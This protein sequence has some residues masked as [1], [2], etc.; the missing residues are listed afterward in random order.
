MNEGSI[1]RRYAKALLELAREESAVDRIGEDLARVQ[2]ACDVNNA[3]LGLVM[4]NPVF[5][6]SERRAV[7]DAV[8][9]T[10]ALHA[11]AVNFMKLLLDKDRFSAL[12]DIVRE[13]GVLADLEANRVRA[14]VTTSGALS[15]GM[16]DA[17][18][19]SLAATTG[20]KVVLETKVD[21][22][23]IGGMVARVGG[24]VYDASLRTRLEEL[25]LSLA[26]PAQS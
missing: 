10:L 7:L 22:A 11:H 6:Q 18:S 14:T 4:S 13:Y 23:L 16:K 3:Q 8:L 20:K 17:V 19:A 5:T 1:G 24:T 9:P 25:Q 15:K 26:T 2:R 12:N 21:P